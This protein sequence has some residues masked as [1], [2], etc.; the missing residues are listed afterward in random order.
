MVHTIKTD[1]S[2][3]FERAFFSANVKGWRILDPVKAL[4]MCLTFT[5]KE[6]FHSLYLTQTE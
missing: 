1:L 2:F 6:W 4:S 5:Q 3:T